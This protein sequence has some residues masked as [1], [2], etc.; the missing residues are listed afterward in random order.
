MIPTG[1]G[2]FVYILERCAGGDMT[3]LAHMAQEAG[4][5]WVALKAANGMANVN[6]A[7]LPAAV[8]ALRA[9]GIQVWGWQYIYGGNIYTGQSIAGREA[10]AAIRNIQRFGFD[11]WILDPEREYKRRGSAAW[12]DVYTTA[13]RA[14][15]PDLSLGLCSYRYPSL[16]PELPWQSFL[17]RVDFHC[18]QVYWMG[19]HNP[20]AQLRQS[21][22]ELRAL[23]ELPVAPVGAAFS[24][25]G[26][27]P[28]IAEI[29]EFDATA[30]ELKL[31]GVAWWVWDGKGLEA[32]PEWWATVAAHDWGGSTPAP[33][34]TL[35]ER[36]ARL[37]KL[38]HGH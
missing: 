14:S 25:R 27:S 32:N 30:R 5:S 15:F 11:G 37:E 35:E 23:R 33:A 1:K 36:V 17:R 21:V 9:V 38:S 22:R 20:G 10:E 13:L 31:G 24:E 3:R 7:L 29:N 4:Y 8:T 12:A 6:E 28:T 16:H 34:L 18:P 2:V 26:W 19:A